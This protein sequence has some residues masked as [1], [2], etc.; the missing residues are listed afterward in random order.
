MSSVRH[1]LIRVGRFFFKYR[2]TIAPFVFGALVLTT[3]PILAFGSVPGDWLLDGLGILLLIVA[4]C[5]RAAVIGY[6]YIIRG[7]KNKQVYAEKLVQEG[8]F[9]HARNP[10]YLGNLLGIF[11]LL[12]I[13]NSPWAYLI[14]VPFSLFFYATIVL[15]EEDYLIAKF[16]A[17]YQLYCRQ[18]PRVIPNFRGLKVTLN[19]MQ[20]DWKRLISK[21][22]GTTFNGGAMILLL[23]ASESYRDLG[24]ERSEGRFVILGLLFLLLVAGFGLARYLKKSKRLKT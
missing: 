10:L 20:F 12:L 3:K 16:G 18:V 9:A 7:G 11:G 14:G 23:L 5:L 4:Q 15:A 17:A 13:H 2:D 8:F 24:Y 22:Y 21:E 6:A 1:R 19:G